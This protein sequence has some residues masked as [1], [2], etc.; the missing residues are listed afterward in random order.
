[1][2][3]PIDEYQDVVVEHRTRS[4]AV[5][6]STSVQLEFWHGGVLLMT[7]STR[8]DVASAIEAAER[9]ADRYRIGADSTVTLR[10]RET[11]SR[12]RYVK[13]EHWDERFQPCGSPIG[14]DEHVFDAHVWD[15]LAGI[16]TPAK[17][18]SVPFRLTTYLA[19]RSA[20]DPEALTQIRDVCELS[21]LPSDLLLHGWSFRGVTGVA[22]R[23]YA[24]DGP[25]AHLRPDE[26]AA[27]GVWYALEIRGFASL[28]LPGDV[29]V[30]AAA[31]ILAEHE[32]QPRVPSEDRF[33]T[34]PVKRWFSWLPAAC[35]VWN[36]DTPRLPHRRHEA[37]PGPA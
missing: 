11:R 18:V 25:P 10:L 36:D 22:N 16:L 19:A 21:A 3:K 31:G 33:G 27:G 26:K 28:G 5:F 35:L 8:T 23:A 30:D 24:L 20:V 7:G 1:M 6:E 4:I 2:R 12:S 15:N 29:D 13:D 14:R 17:T 37:L 9:E 34:I 32:V